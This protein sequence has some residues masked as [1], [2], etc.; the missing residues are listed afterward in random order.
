MSVDEAG[1]FDPAHLDKWRKA[2]HTYLAGPLAELRSDDAVE[3]TARHTV[4]QVRGDRSV[5][6][7]WAH[8]ALLHLLRRA[9]QAEENPLK[10]L[11]SG[12]YFHVSLMAKYPTVPL[13]ILAWYAQ[14][15]DARVRL[16][17]RGAIDH[18]EKRLS[19]LIDRA[20]QQGLVKSNVDARTA[21]GVLVG[22]IQG[23]A[24][25]MN[26]GISRPETLLREAAT[27]FP[28]YL[29]GIRTPVAPFPTGPVFQDAVMA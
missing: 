3:E 24:L 5:L 29:D 20:K 23:L 16:R 25:R 17:I 8:R 28:A 12:L 1:R 6:L 14:T 9:T 11:E 13:T 4:P 26:V 7:S 10:V 21:A 15:N 22:F 19:R 18:Y 2:T 27:V